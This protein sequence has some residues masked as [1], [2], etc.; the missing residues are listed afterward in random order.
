MMEKDALVKLVIEYLK[1][2]HLISCMYVYVDPDFP[3]L[4]VERIAILSGQRQV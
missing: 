3:S 2:V 4:D 1:K